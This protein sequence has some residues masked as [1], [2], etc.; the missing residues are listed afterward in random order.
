MPEGFE[1]QVPPE[2]LADLLAVPHAEGEVP[3]ARPPQGRDGRHHARACSPSP[4]RHAERL[5]FPDWGPKTVEGVPFALV[6]P[7]GDRVPNAIMLHGPIGT[8]PPKMPKS[9]SLPVQ[10]AGQGDPPPQR[11]ER[12]RVPRRAARGRVSMIVRLHYADGTTEDHALKN[13][14]HFA[15]YIGAK[16]VPG[17]KLAFKLG[18]QQVRYLTV[19]PEEEGDRS[20]A[21]SWSR[22]ATAPPRS[23]WR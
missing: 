2:G 21:S 9:V 4:D 12:L 11:R 18:G 15:D 16:D 8:I 6:D 10:R 5:V 17:S 13:G 20:P 22:A 1:K 3:A 14:V 23:S 19:V 7:Q